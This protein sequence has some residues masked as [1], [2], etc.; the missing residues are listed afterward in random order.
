MGIVSG[1]II[2][3]PNLQRSTRLFASVGAMGPQGSGINLAGSVDHYS[4]LPTGLGHEDAGRSWS[5]R[6]DGLAYTWSGTQF[7]AE[8]EGFQIQG[9]QGEQGIQGIQGIQGPKGDTG[10]QGPKGD[11]G[12]Q[13]VKG[14]T[15]E[16]GPKGDTGAQGDQ[17]IQGPQGDQGI[18]GIQGPKGDQGVKG[19]QGIQG[20]KGDQGDGLQLDGSVDTYAN[21][22]TSVPDGQLWATT[23]TGLAYLRQGGIWPPQSSGLNIHGPQGPKGD[24]GTAGA[25]GDKGDKGDTG[26]QGDQGVQGI[27]GPK[28]DKGD[29]G[30]TG[31][32][33]DKGDTGVVDPSAI[34]TAQLVAINAQTSSYTLVTSD[35]NKAVQITNAGAV[36]CTVPTD[37]TMGTAI[38]T[39]GV[40][41]VRQWGAGQVTVVAASGV[42]I[43]ARVGLKL[44]GQYAVAVLYKVAANTWLLVG[45]VIA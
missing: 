43:Y 31:A 2:I 35:Q 7:P 21:L 40:L 1:S 28:G 27:Q 32:K 9:P 13:G 19:D 23:D 12:I 26:L 29:K 22:P 17:G 25:K 14:D 15:G 41:E 11:Q 24:T 6:D 18:Q 10:E 20:P 36:N 16:K 45:D 37:S 34:A 30:D 44:A 4:Q 38:P 5:V 8:G 33:G 3:A 39:G 42:T